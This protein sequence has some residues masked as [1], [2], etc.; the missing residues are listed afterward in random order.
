MPRTSTKQHVDWVDR[1]LINRYLW[2]SINSNPA[3]KCTEPI[4]ESNVMPKRATHLPFTTK[5]HPNI[6][7]V[8][9]FK[10]ITK[11]GSTRSPQGLFCILKLRSLPFKFISLFPTLVNIPPIVFHLPVCLRL[12]SKILIT[13]FSSEFMYIKHH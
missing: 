11:S 5:R 6:S 13:I 9:I 2:R 4:G 3:P 1:H 12:C 7:P 10:K 8:S